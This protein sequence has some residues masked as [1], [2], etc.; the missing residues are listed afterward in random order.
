M[1]LLP[2]VLKEKGVLEKSFGKHNKDH[3][4]NNSVD[5]SFTKKVKGEHSQMPM[6]E[7]FPLTYEA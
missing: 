4:S 2:V 6:Q 5:K 1:H 3:A 7:E